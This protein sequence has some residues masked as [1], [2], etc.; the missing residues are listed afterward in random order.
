M[1]KMVHAITSLECSKG[2]TLPI[3]FDSNKCGCHHDGKPCIIVT[4]RE[5]LEEW[6]KIREKSMKEKYE[7]DRITIP[8]DEDGMKEINKLK[9]K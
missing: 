3:S 2:H 6:I 8:L 4:C 1:N 7:I 9:E 5:C